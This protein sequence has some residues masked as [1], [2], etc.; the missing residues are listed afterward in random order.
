MGG[1]IVKRIEKKLKE[2]EFKS[3]N[4]KSYKVNSNYISHQFYTKYERFVFK[5]NR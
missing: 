1:D 3:L 2:P 4:R 5:I